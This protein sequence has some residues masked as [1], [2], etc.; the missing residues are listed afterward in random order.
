MIIAGLK[1]GLGNQMFQYAMGYRLAHDLKMPFR[2][3]VSPLVDVTRPYALNGLCIEALPLTD[4]ELNIYKPH[5][6]RLPAGLAR[7]SGVLNCL[8]HQNEL[9]FV[10]EKYFHFDPSVLTISSPSY[11]D[12]YWQSEKYFNS[13]PDL[14]RSQFKLAAPMSVSRNAL[15]ALI[16][17]KGASSISVHVRRGDYVTNAVVNAFHGTCAPEWYERTMKLLSEG[18]ENPHFFVFSDDPEWSRAHLP[19]TWPIFF[20]EP[21]TDKRDFEDMHLMA[22][23]HHH[24]IANSSFSWWGAWLNPAQD[25]RVIAPAK[26]FANPMH[27]TRDLIPEAWTKV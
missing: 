21:Q 2:T 6:L 8:P 4:T 13:I 18:I 27:D 1:G 7:F 3:D 10:Q 17:E 19:S 24:I 12:G 16:K 15:A 14:I 5:A 26:W 9:A 22:L 11:F 20:V 23:C 25:K